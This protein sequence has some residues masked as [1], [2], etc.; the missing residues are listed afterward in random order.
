MKVNGDG[1]GVVVISG[2]EAA[3]AVDFRKGTSPGEM[4]PLGFLERLPKW[5]IVIP[6]LFQWLFLSLRYRAAV[7]PSVANPMITSGGLVGEGKMEYFRIMGRQALAATARTNCFT[8]HS[9][10]A[11]TDAV[12]CMRD[13]GLEFPVIVKP[14]IGWCGFGVRRIETLTCL[15]D[16]VAAFPT[17]AR[18]V[19][20]AY[21]PDEGEAG[22]FYVRRPGETTGRLLGLAL[23]YFPRVIGDGC[24]TLDQ[25]IVRD[26][27]LK[28]LVGNRLHR[29]EIKGGQIPH[30]GQRVRLATI[31]STR[32]GGL[33]RDGSALITLSLVKAIDAI[34]LDIREFHFGRLDVRFR[35]EAEL[36]AGEGFTIIEVNGAGSEAI[37][38]WD[39]ALSPAAAFAMILRK[40]E[41]LFE[42]AAA[43]RR[44]GFRPMGLGQL[45]RLHMNQQRLICRYPLSN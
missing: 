12:A 38:A 13:A 7:L 29:I 44:R 10:T 31:G 34:A 21:I 43:N 25:L 20:Q 41:L 16:Y 15:A 40:Q 32:V 45:A 28:R 3:I 17:G 5:L 8:V 2:K 22:I 37:E 11:L 23:R 42:I 33:Y 9:V 24:S 18:L 36:M 14:D 27:R 35:S 30:R 19:L 6:L 4:V 26:V 1:T 39:P